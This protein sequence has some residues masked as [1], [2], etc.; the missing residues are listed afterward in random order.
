MIIEYVYPEIANL[1]DDSANFKYLKEYIPEAEFVE[2]GLNGVPAFVSAEPALIYMGSMSEKSQRLALSRL[3]PYKARLAEL[4]DGG[5][6]FLFTGNSFELFGKYIEQNG[7]RIPALDI[8]DFYAVCDTGKRY[9]GFFLG[10][11]DGVKIT[12]FNSRF[13]NTFPSESAE[14]FA[15]CLRGRGSNAQSL[16]EGVVKNNFIGTYLLGPILVQNPLFTRSLIAE[17]GLS[18][19]PAFFAAGMEAYE[20]RLAEF[21]DPKRE[22][23]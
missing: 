13:S 22:L 11:R 19:E 6:H 16:N 5:T 2:T 3:M 15:R 23:D 8:L 20:K 17:P 4:I 10:E 18:G 7:E 14:C 1:F 9:N 12:A 21:E